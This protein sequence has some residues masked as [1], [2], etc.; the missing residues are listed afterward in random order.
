MN[1]NSMAKVKNAA[2]VSLRHVVTDKIFIGPL[3]KSWVGPQ[4]R[5]VEEPVTGPIV[6]RIGYLVDLRILEKLAPHFRVGPASFHIDDIAVLN[7]RFSSRKMAR[8]VRRPGDHAIG[9][10]SG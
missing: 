8:V 2:A 4:R 1:A 6:I 5:F 7:N 3:E 9:F 10:R